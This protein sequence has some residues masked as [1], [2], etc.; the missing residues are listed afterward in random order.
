[1]SPVRLA[2]T[3]AAIA[4][5]SGCTVHTH[6]VRYVPAPVQ[7]AYAPEPSPYYAPHHYDRPYVRHHEPRLNPYHDRVERRCTSRR[8]G[9]G[10]ASATITT[11]RT[12]HR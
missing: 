5:A 9:K 12:V 10:I 8:V 6:P 4:L 11:C 1:M 3:G 7:P 2:F